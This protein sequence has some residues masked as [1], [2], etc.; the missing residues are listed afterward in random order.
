[1]E[2]AVFIKDLKDLDN[3]EFDRI[4]FGNEFCERLIPSLAKIQEVINYSKNKQIPFT[5]VTPY[6]TDFGIKKIKEIL[7][8]MARQTPNNEVVVN[9]WGVFGLVQSLGQ[10][11]VIGRLLNKQKKG[12]EVLRHYDRLPNE[13]KEYLQSCAFDNRLNGEFLKYLNISRV[14][15]DNLIT[16]ISSRF[17]NASLYFPYV[18][19]TTTRKCKVAESDRIGASKR[20]GIH[21]CNFECE[22]YDIGLSHDC[23][24]ERLILKG[25]TLFLKNQKLP[26]LEMTGITRLIEILEPIV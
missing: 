6:V 8:L 20:Y 3:K 11:P 22:K 10:T 9:D 2:R 23:M 15:L 24:P 18:F 26:D 25:N 16:G 21:D 7:G 19:I 4:Y 14:E 13:A 17:E 5:F 1:M 12:P